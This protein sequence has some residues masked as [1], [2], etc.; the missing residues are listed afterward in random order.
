MISDHEPYTVNRPSL[1]DQSHNLTTR[2]YQSVCTRHHGEYR[3][4][5][6]PFIGKR[7]WD[8]GINCRD[9]N[10]HQSNECLTHTHDQSEQ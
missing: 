7:G 2:T 10:K 1:V 8:C 5:D 3:G 9:A 6:L 4:V